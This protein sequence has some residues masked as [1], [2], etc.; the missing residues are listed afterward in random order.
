[1]SYGGEISN[2]VGDLVFSSEQKSL[3]YLATLSPRNYGGFF[4]NGYVDFEIP[5]GLPDNVIP[6]VRYTGSA[7]SACAPQVIGIIN[8]GHNFTNY[9]W[10]TPFNTGGM[11]FFADLPVPPSVG[12]SPGTSAASPSTLTLQFQAPTGTGN[13]WRDWG[14]PASITINVPANSRTYA[15]TQLI[16]AEMNAQAGEFLY[17]SANCSPLSVNNSCVNFSFRG[18]T[19]TGTNISYN[20]PV[21]FVW[22]I[23]PASGLSFVTNVHSGLGQPLSNH[24]AWDMSNHFIIPAIGDVL[25][26]NNIDYTVT[27]YGATNPNFGNFAPFVIWGPVVL[28]TTPALPT[29]L[30]NLERLRIFTK[31]RYIRVSTGNVASE[32]NNHKCYLFGEVQQTPATGYGMR[33]FNASGEVTFDSNQRALTLAGKGVIDDAYLTGNTGYISD[34]GG[35]LSTV[36]LSQGSIPTNWAI[37][38]GFLG[39]G[40]TKFGSNPIPPS[41]SQQRLCAI[42]FSATKASNTQ[43]NFVWSNNYIQGPT[44]VVA[45]NPGPITARLYEES[46][47]FIIDTDK[48]PS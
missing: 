1:M 25:R 26:R 39:Q 16:A 21:T 8:P 24:M 28:N 13:T 22:S 48:Y 38:V 44:G 32:N 14:M 5:D 31:K 34:S 20:E 40:F 6:F 29:P 46:P 47:F 18:N 43:L 35:V 11:R 45:G 37:N 33:C 23:P 36:T 27:G 15:V 4:T 19:G 7:P 3:V 42:Q 17:A 10:N 30:T 41:T 12:I 2:S 9:F